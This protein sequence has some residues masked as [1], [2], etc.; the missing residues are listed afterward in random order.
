MSGARLPDRVVV[1]DQS[2]PVDPA[3]LAL[4][5]EF[6]AVE[7]IESSS[8]GL[9]RGQNEGIAACK[10]QVV[11]FTD[12]DVLVDREWLGNMVVALQR[13]GKGAAVTGRVLSGPAEVPDGVALSLATDTEAAVFEGLIR[14][15]P[16]AGNS[17]GFFRSTFDEHGGFDERLGPGARFS[18]ASDNDFGYR[19]LRAGYCIH[20][21]PEAIVYHRAIRAGAA[22]RKVNRD[23]GRGQAAFLAKHALAGDVWARSRFRTTFAFWLRRLVL[24]PL[25]AR[26]IR[27]HGDVTYL[28]AFVGGALEWSLVERAARRRPGGSHT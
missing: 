3:V 24:R 10:T 16:L 22:L 19:L 25:R 17:M 2:D 21:I 9:A 18:S 26:S 20:Y 23:Y 13:V 5:V 15:D 14:R 11:L 27:G 8:V 4:A 12:D 7:V 28:A 1:V 6:G